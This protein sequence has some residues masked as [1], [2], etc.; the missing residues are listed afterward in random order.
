[1][2]CVSRAA[3]FRNL[4]SGPVGTNL[5]QIKPAELPARVI[6]WTA[7]TIGTDADRKAFKTKQPRDGQ[8]SLLADFA[9]IFRR[10]YDKRELPA[11]KEAR[12]LGPKILE[13]NQQTPNRDRLEMGVPWRLL[14]EWMGGLHGVKSSSKV[15]NIFSLLLDLC[16]DLG[17]A[18]P[19]TCVQDG[20]VFRGYR[21]G[22]DVKFS[23][24]ELAL[25]FETARGFLH[26][27]RRSKIPRLT[28]E[29]LLVFLIKVG[30]SQGFLEP[31]YGASGAEGT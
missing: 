25:A 4:G 13:K 19:V 27:N 21:H 12:D 24:G 6:N 29:K 31:L 14:V 28:L 5:R 22:E 11:R 26:G 15:T 9:E 30:A 3:C 23:D 17:I 1:M 8:I 2:S 18:V 10:I 20:V 7:N 16:N